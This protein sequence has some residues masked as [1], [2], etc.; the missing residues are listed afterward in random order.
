[1]VKEYIHMTE[2]RYLYRFDDICPTM[3]WKIWD[4]I[5]AQLTKYEVS[6]ILAVVPDNHDKELVVDPPRA[7]FW[8]R[9]RQ[10]QSMG[11][12]IALH[13]YQHHYVNKNSGILHLTPRSEFAGVPREEQEAKLKDGLAIFAEHGVRADAW[14]AP[15]HSFDRNT[16]EIL[17]KLG[18]SVISD[19]LWPLP[20]T[21]R[22]G[23]TW[24][25]QQLWSFRKK[26]AGIWTICCH[27]NAWSERKLERFCE[28]IVSHASK[29]TTVNAV[30]GEYA[31]RKQTLLNR[32]FGFYRL[33]WVHRVRS[34][35]IINILRR[36]S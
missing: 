24:I 2:T 9:V 6:P 17:A 14:V 35:F 19:G 33:I 4:A 23:T 29:T 34:F 1:M 11:W 18:V 26:S 21:E 12:T 27:H 13:G 10:W 22:G 31:G 15:S 28:E 8:D 5:E 7:D 32:W 3:N 36:R 16:V 25:P 30:L 20:F